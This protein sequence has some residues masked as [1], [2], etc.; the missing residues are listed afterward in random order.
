MEKDCQDW[1]VLDKLGEESL[2]I[3]QQ[4]PSLSICQ[5]LENKFIENKDRIRE[6]FSRAHRDFAEKYL[7]K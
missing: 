4:T 5:K 3:S 2:S 7:T 1:S 6:P